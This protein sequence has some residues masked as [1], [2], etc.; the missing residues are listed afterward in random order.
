[1]LKIDKLNYSYDEKQILKDISFKVKIPSFV[2]V[3]G[4][5]NSGKT[6]LIKCMA[7]IMPIEESVSIDDI[8]L[9]KKNIRK[10][11]IK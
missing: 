3:I 4:S 10:Y 9:N 1:M 11:S 2:S 6:T 5:N 8:V 7:G